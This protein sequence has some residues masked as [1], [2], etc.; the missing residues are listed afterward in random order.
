VQ[1]IAFDA[2]SAAQREQ[3][4]A[5]LVSALAHFP[6]AWHDMASALEEVASFTADPDRMAIAALDGLDVVGW[7]GR[8]RHYSTAW[9]LHPLAIHPSHQGR[10]YG[11]ALVKALEDE[12]R[13]AGVCTIWL[14]TD[15]DFG[16]TSLFEVDLYP[17]VLAHLRRLA[18]ADRQP[19]SGRHPYTFYRRLGYIV[20]G[21]LPDV[22]GL[23][24]HDILMAKRI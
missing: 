1:T 20:V 14:G 10:G 12:A 7:I 4:A 24:R 6:S 16:G 5:I 8:I 19:S 13:R 2:T 15:D 11:T 18:P 17:D 23:G 22:D 21:V 9:E 3:A